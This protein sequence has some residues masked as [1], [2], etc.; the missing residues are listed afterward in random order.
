MV[1]KKCIAFGTYSR[2][3]LEATLTMEDV[4]IRLEQLSQKG[5]L[6]KRKGKYEEIFSPTVSRKELFLFYLTLYSERKSEA[7]SDNYDGAY[8]VILEDLK[9]KVLLLSYDEIKK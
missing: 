3:P 2:L 5:I 4:L 9:N 7:E 1:I 8:G 6:Q